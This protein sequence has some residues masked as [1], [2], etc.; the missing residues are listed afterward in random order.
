MHNLSSNTSP[1]CYRGFSM[2]ELMVAMALSIV[3]L[4]G[5]ISIYSNSKQTYN[6][7]EGLSRLQEN[8]RFAMDRLSRQVSAAGYLG[9]L[10]TSGSSDPLSDKI[11]NVLSDQAGF[12]N[13]SSPIFGE[14]GTGLNGSDTLT[15]SRANA[16]T[17]VTVISPMTTS[18]DSLT[19]NTAQVGYA[20]LEQYD[21]VTVSDCSHASTFMITNAPDGTGVINH[22]TG[23]TD[24]DTSQSNATE[25]LQW[26][27]GSDEGSLAVVMELEPGTTS[28][29]YSIGT[30]AA[31]ANAGGVCSAASPGFCA[32]F[33]G[34]NELVE[35]V[36]DM[37]IIY[38]ID[39]NGDTQVDQYSD[40]DSV[41]NWDNVVSVR[42]SLTVNQVE[43]VQGSGTGVTDGIDRTYQSVFRLRSRGA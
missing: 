4:S 36:E 26:V 34:N 19:L 14:E 43:R 30:S 3:L 13:F 8:A 18:I 31:G 15:L 9:C 37:Q 23:V 1:Q 17:A 40:A 35:G 25:D 21:V 29:V 5:V 7:Q 10:Q 33:E 22:A 11:T 6:R 41:T 27:Y 16:G 20:G 24:P 28:T 39:N 12:N 38:G 42:V 2:V 32:L